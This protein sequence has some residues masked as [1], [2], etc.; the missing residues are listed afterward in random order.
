MAKPPALHPSPNRTAAGRE[1]PIGLGWIHKSAIRNV[2]PRL[3]LP[4]C[5]CLVVMSSVLDTLPWCHDIQPQ[6]TDG[7][8]DGHVGYGGIAVTCGKHSHRPA[9]H[10]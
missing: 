2:A 7:M 9:A 4:R 5:S 3:S 1:S 6:N 8:F 10:R